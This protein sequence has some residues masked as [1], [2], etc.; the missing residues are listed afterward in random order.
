MLV[1][2]IDGSSFFEAVKSAAVQHVEVPPM[3]DYEIRWASKEPRDSDE[4]QVL[5]KA[6]KG[7]GPMLIAALT[8]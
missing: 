6:I 4:K 8:D 1:I 7:R 5:D 3:A 2:K